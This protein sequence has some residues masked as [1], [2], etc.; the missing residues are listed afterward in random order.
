[1]SQ[2]TLG[3]RQRRDVSGR[4][5]S[6]RSPTL[7]PLVNPDLLYA[8]GNGPQVARVNLAQSTRIA[9]MLT[10]HQ[11]DKFRQQ[12]E[13]TLEKATTALRRHPTPMT[14]TSQTVFLR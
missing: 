14:V 8:N 1:M 7:F 9:L 13:Q 5:R 6:G 10:P 4:T 2:S 3:A 11:G 12:A